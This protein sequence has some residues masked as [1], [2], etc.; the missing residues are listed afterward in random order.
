MRKLYYAVV[1][2]FMISPLVVHAEDTPAWL[3]E[4]IAK[5]QEHPRGQ[6]ITTYNYRGE[7][8]YAIMPGCCDQYTTVYHE[9]GEPICAPD[10][11][12]K[13]N[14]DGKCPDFYSEAT[15]SNKIYPR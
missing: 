14:G 8:V 9:D 11:G 2:A 12:L 13:G 1:M 15:Q 4:R 6:F 3:A 10:G 5:F 7:Q